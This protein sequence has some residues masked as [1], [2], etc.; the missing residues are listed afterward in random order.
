[1]HDIGAATDS[2][3]RQRFEVQG[4]DRTA[5]FLAEPGVPTSDAYRVWQA[6][7]LHTS[8]GIARHAVPC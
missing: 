2:P 8:P 4:V 7:A 3:N 1:M 5:A 6:I